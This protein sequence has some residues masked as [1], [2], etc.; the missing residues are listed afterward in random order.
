MTLVSKSILLASVLAAAFL[1]WSPAYAQTERGTMEVVEQALSQGDTNSLTTIASAR[2]ELTIFGSAAMYSR[3]QAMYVLSDFFRQHPP[4]NVSFSDPSR[5]GANWFVMGEY[6][7]EGGEQPLRV[8]VRL[9][10]R[11]GKW[12]LRELRIDR[13]AGS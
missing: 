1:V 7:Y 12:E 9:R 10:A 11:D 4:T 8:F 5:S 6:L 13:P 2:I 3:G